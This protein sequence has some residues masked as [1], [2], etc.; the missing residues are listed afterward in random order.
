MTGSPP[1]LE[2]KRV[3]KRFGGTT[4]LNEVSWSIGAGEI[5]C[6]VGENGSGKSTIIKLISGVHEPDPGGEIRFD[7]A[8]LSRITPKLSKRLGIQVIYQDLSLFPNLTVAENIAIDDLAGQGASLAPIKRMRARAAEILEGLGHSLPLDAVVGSLPVAQRQMVAICRG[9]AAKARVLFMDEPTASLTRHEVDRLFKLVRNLQARGITIVF[10]SHRLDE[11]VEIAE[12]VSV[13]RDGD[14]VGTFPVSE[15][16]D[17]KLGELMTGTQIVQQVQARAI[18]LSEPLLATKGLGRRGEFE[19][20]SFTLMRGEVLGITGLLGAGR[21]ELALTLFGMTPADAGVVHLAGAVLP[22][23]NNQDAIRAGIAYVPEDRLSQGLNLPQ[24]I[25]DNIAITALDRLKDG[26]GRVTGGRRKALAETWIEKLGVRAD[27]ALAPANTLSGGNQQRIVLAKWL[28]TEPKVLILDSPTVGVDIR[29]KEGI[30]Q[31]V[32]Q[33][34]RSGVAVLMITDE[35]PEA[36]FN[37]DRILHMRQGRI[38]GEFVPGRESIEQV[39]EAV[40]A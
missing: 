30:Y 22:L 29:N 9:L 28:A 3:T 17:H 21:T 26:L 6:L 32:R 24:S 2:L 11:I 4:A 31:I 25:A 37:T 39:Q 1:L 35:I 5:H 36:Y 34:A 7:G 13:L 19:D 33:L 14:M 15:V 8:L 40:Y 20:V 18:D 16:D 12:R 10:V 27:D 38:V 23:N